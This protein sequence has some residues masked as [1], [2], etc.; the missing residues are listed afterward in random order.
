MQRLGLGHR[1]KTKG[2]ASAKGGSRALGFQQSWQV[3]SGIVDPGSGP[4]A[5]WSGAQ[6]W[7]LLLCGIFPSRGLN[8]CLLHWQA[9]YLPLSKQGSL[10]FFFFLCSLSAEASKM[11]SVAT[12]LKKGSP[13]KSK[14]LLASSSVGLH[15]RS[16]QCRE[17]HPRLPMI[18]SSEKRIP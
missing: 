4:Q 10:F 15:L 8:P 1:C 6:A 2:E 7:L 12:G 16:N 17:R 13:T 18:I 11:S 9:D 5:Q 14:S 3:G